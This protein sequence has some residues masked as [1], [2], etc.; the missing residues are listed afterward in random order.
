MPGRA[1]WNGSVKADEHRRQLEKATVVTV[2]GCV[3]KRSYNAIVQIVRKIKGPPSLQTK[4][5]IR[6]R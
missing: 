6:M 5:W 3:S 1:A 4:L 2:V